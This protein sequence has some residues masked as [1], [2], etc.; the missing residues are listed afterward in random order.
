MHIRFATSADA[1]RIS[2]LLHSLSH[3]YTL[4][5]TGE[6]AE[7]F[8][9][10]ISEAGIRA[11]LARTDVGYLVAEVSAHSPLAGAAAMSDKGAVLHLF[12]APMYQG[13]GLGRRLWELLRDRALR[14]GNPGVF[15]VNSSIGAVPVYERFGFR[16]NGDRV[17]K[18]GGAYIPMV[19]R[20]PL[21]P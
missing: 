4:S 7:A 18:H 11:M 9:E 16:V 20:P 5:P 14:A 13:R 3:T 10:T 21:E 2:A 19:L 15:T 12:V 8:F 6:G 1:T 17:E